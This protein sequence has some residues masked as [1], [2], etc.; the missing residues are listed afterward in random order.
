MGNSAT[1][2]TQQ[3]VTITDDD[4]APMLT[5]SVS[6]A[7]IAEAAGT[8]TVTVTASGSTFTTNQTIALALAGTA[9]KTADY[10]ISAESLTLLAGQT[11][12]TATVTAVQDSSD[13]PDETVLITA[14]VVGGSDFGTQQTVTINDDDAA[15]TL[16]VTVNPATID[17]AA[18]TSTVT[19]T[20]SGTTFTDQTITLTLAG[21]A[22]KTA[23]YTIS[24]ESLTLLAGQTSVTATVTAVQD[25]SDEPDE[26]VLITASVVGGSDFGTQQTVT[27]NDDDAH[28]R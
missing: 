1:F 16:T 26:T 14:S 7:T 23:D 3:T 2:G 9:T 15:P 5:V 17:E 12:V 10:T 4:G 11:S 28:R 22:T 25:S 27:I 21:T 8:S 19:V 20:A 13:E 6:P 18:G 24:A